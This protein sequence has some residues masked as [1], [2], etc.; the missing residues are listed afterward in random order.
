MP[1]ET[2]L[3]LD[4]LE[5]FPVTAA[6]IAKWTR[7]EVVLSRVLEAVK[8]GWLDSYQEEEMKPHCDHCEE[9]RALCSRRLSPLG[10][11]CDR[12]AARPQKAITGAA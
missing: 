5:L 4:N 12:S 6:K 11:S 10:E 7:R 3:L 9:N 8:E 1:A 2:V